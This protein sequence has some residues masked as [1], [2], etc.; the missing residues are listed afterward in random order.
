MFSDDRDRLF[1][2]A[3]ARRLRVDAGRNAPGCLDPEVLAAYHERMLS[4]EEMSDL[5]TH[6]VSCLLCQEILARLEATQDI[7]EKQNRESELVL[8]RAAYPSNADQIREETNLPAEGAKIAEARPDRVTEFRTRKIA[9]FG[10][11]APAGAIAAGLLLW[12][13]IRGF[14][15]EG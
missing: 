7:P 11:V 2:Q 12:V 14:R 15:P 9:V 8:A 10:W 3:L 1:E 5:K 6:L 13:G 4:P